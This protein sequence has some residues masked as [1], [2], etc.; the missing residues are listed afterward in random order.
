MLTSAVLVKLAKFMIVGMGG[1]VLDFATTY[2]LK[3]KININK[4]AANSVGFTLAGTSNYIFNRVWAF[5]SSSDNVIGQYLVFISISLI[6]L[7][8]LNLSVWFLHERQNWNFYISKVL[9]LFMVLA[10][11]FTAHLLVTFS[12]I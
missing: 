10:W 11:T 12:K 4:Y 1:T 2:L 5:Q 8:I 7:G 6:G 9:A 3:E